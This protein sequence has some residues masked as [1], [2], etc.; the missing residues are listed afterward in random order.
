MTP[1]HRC[2]R[3]PARLAGA[4][5]ALLPVLPI[6]GSLA[7]QTVPAPAPPAASTL[8]DKVAQLEKLL[9]QTR[10]EL[11]AVRAQLAAQGAS[12]ADQQKLQ[13]LERRIEIL[14]REIE[15]LKIGEAAAPSEDG[16]SRYG[17]GPAAAKVYRGKAG[18]SIGGYGEFQYNNLAS[19]R[20]DGAPS[21]AASHIDLAR[22]VVYLGY[23]FDDRFVLNTEIEFEHA[24]TA[25][26]KGGEVAIEF[27]YLDW[28][29]RRP[30]NLRA[31][32]VLV[33]LGLVNEFHEPTVFSGTRRPDVETFL[34]PTTWRELGAGVW[35]E[36]GAF[37]Y[38]GYVTNG[39][40]A[41]GYD[42]LGIREGRQEGS[43]ALAGSWAGSGRLDWAGAAGL[44]VGGAFFVG[45]SG[46]GQA[47][48]G[49]RTFA[50]LTTLFEVHGIWQWRG[51]D[52]RGLYVHTSV[53]DAA[54]I[55]QLND[56]AG[57]ESV[58]SR[59]LGWYLQGGYDLLW[60]KPG[61]RT[62]LTLFTRY[63]K[64]DTQ[65]AVPAGYRKN[66]AN[67]RSVWTAGLSF[68]PIDRLVVKADYQWKRNAASTG[69]NQ[70]N[71][72]LGYVF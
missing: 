56:L 5:L 29:H 30:F 22:A 27:A 13:E 72:G 65:S 9:A 15:A 39:L 55:N 2:L 17:V 51:L 69:I 57:D 64:L 14:A 26:D 42:A 50:G 23:K 66:P 1:S 32:L 44:V 16:S 4:V 31:G 20:Q 49:G 12:Q 54:L 25:S 48:A 53:S 33:P 38:R 7:A 52:L 34:I 35:G 62:S 21:E 71:V 47:L 59:Q 41:A 70:W 28:M 11:A 61:A 3:R 36:A 58:G 63:E 68:K 19:R 45:G 46:Q 40:N 18:V 60:L 43:K 6:A 67:D 10:Q 8:Q 24:V 37:T